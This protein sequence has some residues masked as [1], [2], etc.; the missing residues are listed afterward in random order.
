MFFFCW[1]YSLLFSFPTSSQIIRIDFPSMHSAQTNTA[2]CC[3]GLWSFKGPVCKILQENYMTF[4][5]IIIIITPVVGAASHPCAL[6]WPSNCVLQSN[7]MMFKVP[8]NNVKPSSA[9]LSSWSSP[10]CGLR[11]KLLVRRKTEDMSKPAGAT[12]RSQ[13]GCPGLEGAGT[14]HFVGNPLWPLDVF[15]GS[16]NPA[17]KANY[18]C[19]QCVI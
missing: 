9:E 1:C 13:A 11:V 19:S 18:S 7:S 17:F 14:K 5:V 12:L 3:A 10:A 4:I 8:C 16:E 15:N 6:S 2:H